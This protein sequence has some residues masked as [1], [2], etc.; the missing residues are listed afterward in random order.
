MTTIYRTAGAWGSGKGSNLTPAEVDGN[1][2]GHETRIVTLEAVGGPVIITNITSD[3]TSLTV[4]MSDS[5]TFGPFAIPTASPSFAPL[6]LGEIT[7]TDY[8]LE[9]GDANSYQLCTEV[10]TI[11]IPHSDDVPFALETEITFR[12]VSLT[13]SGL[14]S[15]VEGNTDVV[16]NPQADDPNWCDEIGATVT[17]KKVGANSWDIIGRLANGDSA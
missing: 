1:F 15:F 14:M 11:T 8:I 6:P 7:D 2:Y 13:S 12:V 17:I 4:H 3:G 5:S 9:A 10:E 16:I